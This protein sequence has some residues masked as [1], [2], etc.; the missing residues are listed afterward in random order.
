MWRRA[1]VRRLIARLSVM[2]QIQALPP[3]ASPDSGSYRVLS[4]RSSPLKAQFPFPPAVSRLS[5][6]DE[7]VIAA[8]DPRRPPPSPLR[9]SPVVVFACAE[10]PSES[11]PTAELSL[12]F[13]RRPEQWLSPRKIVDDEFAEVRASLS[14]GIAAIPDDLFSSEPEQR[15]PAS[16]EAD[17]SA[18]GEE[19]DVL[20]QTV[21]LRMPVRA[22]AFDSSAAEI[23]FVLNAANESA[24]DAPDF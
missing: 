11:L 14:P 19:D 7:F 17:E 23:E 24:S 1:L 21:E 9:T 10:A 13:K 18:E 20:A 3:T 6:T 4:G 15:F 2:K 22:D 12:G 16:R 8:I 5:V